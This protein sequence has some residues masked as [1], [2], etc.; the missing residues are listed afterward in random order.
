M[1]PRAQSVD[2]LHCPLIS[3]MS[4]PT[5]MALTTTLIPMTSWFVSSVPVL[6]STLAH[7]NCTQTIRTEKSNRHHNVMS[8]KTSWCSLA[9]LL[10]LQPSPL[11]DFSDWFAQAK[12]LGVILDSFFSHSHRQLENPVDSTL[13]IQPEFDHSSSPSLLHS[14]LSHVISHLGSNILLPDLPAPTFSSYTHGILSAGSTAILLNCK[15]DHVF[16]W[17]AIVKKTSSCSQESPKFLHWLGK[18]L[19]PQLQPEWPP[20]CSC[21]PHLTAFMSSFSQPWR[22]FL[23]TCTAPYFLMPFAY[24]SPSHWGLPWPHCREWHPLWSF[25]FLHLLYLFHIFIMF[26][27]SLPL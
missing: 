27:L 14:G 26:I 22:L 11:V 19:F 2:L 25:S 17:L 1:E 12:N 10:L 15:G 9:G 21:S 16:L 6:E 4:L 8:P 23:W 24:R 20:C 18:F 7:S 3:F 13:K 5:L